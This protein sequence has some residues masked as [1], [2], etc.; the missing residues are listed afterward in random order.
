MMRVLGNFD[1][2]GLSSTDN[3]LFIAE[4]EGSIDGT[5]IEYQISVL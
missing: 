1:I 3:I 5:L 4:R 2:S